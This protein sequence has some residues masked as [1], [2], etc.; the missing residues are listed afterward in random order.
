MQGVCKKFTIYLTGQGKTPMLC[1]IGA[2][3]KGIWKEER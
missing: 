1:G 3:L 2:S